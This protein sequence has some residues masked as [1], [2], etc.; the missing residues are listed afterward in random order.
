M[1]EKLLVFLLIG[2]IAMGTPLLK[3]A[4][5][6]GISKG[7][8]L[9][10]TLMLTIM[11]TAGTF[12]MYYVENRYWGGLSFYGAVFLVPV[13]FL[14]VAPILQ[15][16]YSSAMD[17]CAVGECV[18]LALMKIHCIIGGCC[19]GRVLFKIPSGELIR[20]PSRIV[21]MS[22]AIV[23]FAVL[24]QWS[25]KGNKHGVLY[26]WYML[27]YGCTRFGLNILR[28]AWVEKNMILPFGNIWSL[29]AIV[30]GGIWLISIRKNEYLYRGN[31]D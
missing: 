5:N 4:N 27:L 25:Q 12:L 23:L 21:E 29:V 2:T 15:I 24:F 22:V 6:Y 9:I 17:F 8:I 30:V 7:K 13:M 1:N 28:E 20:F 16:P 26:S 31:D 19:Q 14:A 10:L 3:M 18:M 11:G